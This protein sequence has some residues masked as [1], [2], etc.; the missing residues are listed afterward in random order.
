MIHL[1]ILFKGYELS[2]STSG[3]SYIRKIMP[4]VGHL[5]TDK[6]VKPDPAKVEA[7]MKMPKPTDKKV[8][9]RL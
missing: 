9:Q 5:L 2:H 3:S 8:V 7:I 6:G 1:E 4:C